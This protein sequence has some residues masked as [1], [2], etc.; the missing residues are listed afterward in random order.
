[1]KRQ[2]LNGIWQMSES[3]PLSYPKYDTKVPGSVLSGLLDNGAIEDPF[4]RDNEYA[5]RDL[6]WK[7]YEFCRTFQVTKELL[8]E[9]CVDLVC[10][11]LDTLTEIYI[12]GTFFDRTN[13]MHRTY[14]LPVR[15][16]LQVG[17]NQ[18]RIVFK[19]TLQYMK[20]YKYEEHRKITYFNLGTILGSNL[21][22]KAH[23]MFGWDW[24][25]QLPDAGIFRDIE[26]Q[27]YSGA[28]LKDTNII[29]EHREKEVYITYKTKLTLLDE[30]IYE[31]KVRTF[32]P[33][34]N[35]IATESKE[36]QKKDV[37]QYGT[38]PQE[39]MVEEKI[40]V[41]NPQIWWPNGYGEHPL[42]K[43]EVTLQ[44][45]G[46]VLESN[47]YTMGLRTLEVSQEK[48]Q[49]GSEFA[50]KVN[51]IK[52][53]TKGANYIPED[54]VYS[55][56]TLERQE[57]LVRSSVKANY[58]CL[59]IWGGGY[60][61]SDAFYDLCD[62]YGLLIWQDLMY[63]CNVYDITP[64]FEENIVQ[65]TLDN[66][67]RLRHHACLGIWCGNNE[68]ESAWLEWSELQDQTPYIRADYIKQFEHI[69]PK[70]VATADASTY[71]WP[72]SPS[73]GGSFDDPSDENRGDTHYWK[74]WHGMVPFSEYRK[75]YFRFC[76]EFGFQSFPCLKT[77]E[78]YT[79]V[80]DRNIFSKVM[81]SH[82]KNNS[83]NGKILYYLSENFPYPKDFDS[84]LY[85]S[86]ILQ[87]VAIKTGV[88]HFRRNRGRC[89]GAT[90]WQLNDN[91]P[92]A[93]WS[94]IDYFGRW[95]ALHYMAKVF[96]AP[97]AA[98]LFRTDDTGYQMEAY[99][100][101]ETL[102]DMEV[103]AN[104]SLKNMKC[105]V[106]SEKQ[107][108]INVPK[109]SSVKVG[110]EDYSELL[111]A[112][113]KKNVEKDSLF[114]ELKV[115]YGDGS[116]QTEVETFVPYKHMCLPKTKIQKKVVETETGYEIILGA[117]TFANYVELDFKDADVI[118]SDNY[119][120]LTG[121]EKK[122]ILLK[123]DIMHG[124]FPDAKDLEDRLQVRSVCD[125]YTYE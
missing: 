79:E 77:V 107:I 46:V 54:C 122:V 121:A 60:Y 2:T 48:D 88:E 21:I 19:S 90:Y 80:E 25:P 47:D 36:V 18:I 52:I 32:G 101:N 68:M 87:G 91:W 28:K 42:Y 24:G 53:F 16:R 40:Q 86:Q 83:A 44:K 14:R 59:R 8:E 62:R 64:E 34:G 58:N 96:F 66:V 84:L 93:S 15:D 1:M 30:D 75:H 29:Q 20:D 9:T 17:E 106:L 51:G 7:D 76:S 57:H 5:T 45:N 4:Y 99:V 26:L 124:T 72:S 11:G 50:F 113:D 95:K 117:D 67:T 61:P 120:P 70:A 104:L 98:S 65:E 73:S 43:V 108:T 38:Q 78:S 114:V 100:A 123:E 112:L 116:T 94:S 110:E 71:Y 85:V 105:Q 89:M 6:F 82:Q 102:Q 125:S 118:F 49:W 92:V 56:I 119:F 35:E 109:L 12:N 74:V 31:V 103:R 111:Q 63:A 115:T 37:I 33:D 13:N 81:E 27:A 97:M 41:K 69:L 55:R 22:R 39:A 10:Y 23:S 3:G